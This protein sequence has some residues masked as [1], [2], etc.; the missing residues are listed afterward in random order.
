MPDPTYKILP[1]HISTKEQ[2]GDL[3]NKLND[4]VDKYYIFEEIHPVDNYTTNDP[5]KYLSANMGRVLKEYVDSMK[6]LPEN[7][8]ADGFKGPQGDPGPKGP[9]GPTGNMGPKGPTGDQG[10]PGKDGQDG[11]DGK[12]GQNGNDGS[13]GGYTYPIDLFISGQGNV[14]FYGS[15]NGGS[16]SGGTISNCSTG[17]SNPKMVG[18][19]AYTSVASSSGTGCL[20]PYMCSYGSSARI[21][22][23]QSKWAPFKNISSCGCSVFSIG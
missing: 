4:L 13:A 14:K 6:N 9:K 7:K 10:D 8:G 18:Y 5:S 20:A 16:L 21:Y 23:W 15:N 11:P 17:T 22:A 19:Q 12:P 3:I 2:Q 1:P